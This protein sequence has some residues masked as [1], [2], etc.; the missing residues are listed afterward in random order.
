LVSKIE[1]QQE[2]LSRFAEAEGFEL[3]R[4]FMEIETGKARC[5]GA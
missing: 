3:V 5:S 2:A 4:V 1:A